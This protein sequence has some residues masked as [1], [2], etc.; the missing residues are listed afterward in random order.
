MKKII[1]IGECSL[2]IVFGPDGQPLGSMPGGRIPNAAAILARTG[3]RVLMASE[4]TTDGVGNMVADFLQAS[5]A[6][7]SA[8]DRYSEGRTP[9]NVF[10]MGAD[11]LPSLTR[12]EKYAD[13]DEGFDIVWPRVEEGDIVVFGGYYAIAPRT[14]RRL[15]RFLENAREMK[16]VLVYL[17]GFLPVQEPRITRVM[18]AILENLELADLVLTRNDDLN[19]IF[20]VQ[21]HGCYDK[22]VG[23]YCRS[24][25][26]VDPVE[27]KIVYYSGREYSEVSIPGLQC[28]TLLWNA[29]ALAGVT[30]ALVACDASTETLEEPGED[31]RREVL[32]RAV[33]SAD[34]AYGSATAPWQLCE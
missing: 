20:G 17:P 18:P 12:Y 24:L 26:N 8:L 19:L 7:L 11:G 6:D 21:G 29:G 15:S 25:V 31:F 14:R 33:K 16:A 2:N 4:L 32:E 5:G 23:F 10:T 13:D 34:E 30:D 3:L 22:H 28:R 27:C 9:L 1:C